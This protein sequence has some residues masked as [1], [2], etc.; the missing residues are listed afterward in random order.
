MSA[1]LQA[2][3][4][5][6]GTTLASL[7]DALN[8]GGVPESRLVAEWLMAE[9]VGCPRLE[10]PVH[11]ERDLAPAEEMAVEEEALLEPV[12]DEALFAPSEE[13]A[14]LEPIVED[15][16]AFAPVTLEPEE[17]DEEPEPDAVYPS[18]AEVLS[19]TGEEGPEE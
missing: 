12:E 18:V 9:A 8:E 1:G 5:Y 14:Q 19:L 4:V 6:A 11:P 17:A 10:L 3:S 13:E 16:P 2:A 7:A 15:A